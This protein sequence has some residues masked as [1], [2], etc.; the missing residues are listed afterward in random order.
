MSV[1]IPMRSQLSKLESNHF[2]NILSNQIITKYSNVNNT[3]IKFIK[4]KRTKPSTLTLNKDLKENLVLDFDDDMNMDLELNKEKQKIQQS[5][6]TTCDYQQFQVYKWCLDDLKKFAIAL[7]LKTSGSTIEL[8]KRILVHFILTRQVVKIQKQYRRYLVQTFFRLQG[9]A[10]FC[11]HLCTNT[12]DFITMD[13]FIIF[14]KENSKITIDD[15][16]DFYSYQDMDEFIYGFQLNSIYEYIVL[17]QKQIKKLVNPYNR[18]ELSP[19]IIFNIYRMSRLHKILHFERK[20]I[21]LPDEPKEFALTAE[22]ILELN[23]L[24]LFQHINALGN[25]ADSKWLLDLNK[26]KVIRFLQYLI[27]IWDYRAELSMEMKCLICP[28]NGNPFLHIPI[29][30]M[31]EYNVFK[32]Q[33]IIYPL[34]KQLVYSSATTSNQSLGAIY[35]LG[36][37]SLVNPIVAEALPML[38]ESFYTTNVIN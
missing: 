7:R 17:H 35:I 19:N 37:L 14:T 15:P 3:P 5:I 10:R 2:I 4:K 23:Y 34:L 36:A 20:R 27:D 16:Y 26:K 31:H 1:S 33:Q 13:P 21:N 38:Y 25:Y 12:H 8:T 9:P 18:S 22:K 30:K 28:P 11:R 6:I 32:I 24:D 29:Y